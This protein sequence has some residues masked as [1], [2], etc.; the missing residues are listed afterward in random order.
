M[1][2]FC[3]F[4][5]SS[6]MAPYNIKI[7]KLLSNKC[8][9]F[10]KKSIMNFDIFSENF[11]FSLETE[12]R[13]AIVSKCVFIL[14][15]HASLFTFGIIFLISFYHDSFK[16]IFPPVRSFICIKIITHIEQ[17]FWA[18]APLFTIVEISN[19]FY[20]NRKKTIFR[21]T[22]NNWFPR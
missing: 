13:S 16:I 22:E 21:T 15:E 20:K 9:S 3:S 1:S 6:D 12:V 10:V 4:I 5:S 7:P 17:N 8:I 2:P 18:I 11:I 14:W 19:C